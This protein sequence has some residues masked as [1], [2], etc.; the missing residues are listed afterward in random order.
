VVDLKS[1]RGL[2]L[3]SRGGKTTLVVSDSIVV[4]DPKNCSLMLRRPPYQ[5]TEGKKG[6]NID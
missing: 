2:T 6:G 1:R 4:S 5:A 3:T